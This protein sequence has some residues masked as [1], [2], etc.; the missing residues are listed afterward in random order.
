VRLASAEGERIRKRRDGGTW[1]MSKQEALDA[2]AAIDG[3]RAS[4]I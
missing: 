2:D 3:E 4:S 1:G